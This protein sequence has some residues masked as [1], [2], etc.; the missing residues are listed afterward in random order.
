V[1]HPVGRDGALERRAHGILGDEIAEGLGPVLA[2][3]G[4]VGHERS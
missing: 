4:E 3:E 2:R 1:R